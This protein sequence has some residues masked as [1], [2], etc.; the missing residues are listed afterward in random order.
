MIVMKWWKK[1]LV[2]GVPVGLVILFAGYLYFSRD[3]ARSIHDIVGVA[4][5]TYGGDPVEALMAYVDDDAQGIRFRN[6]AVWALGQL[7]DRRALPV[8]EKHYIGGECDHGYLICQYE[9]E[10][11]IQGSKRNSLRIQWWPWKFNLELAV[12]DEKP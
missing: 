9:L 4:Q 3:I 1:V 8:L 10:K 2:Y 5:K 6:R 11:A 12:H 7:S